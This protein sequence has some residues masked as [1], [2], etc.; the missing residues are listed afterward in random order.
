MEGTKTRSRMSIKLRSCIIII[1]ETRYPSPCP[2]CIKETMS[3]ASFEMSQDMVRIIQVR[4]T[5]NMHKLAYCTHGK[6]A[7]RSS[8]G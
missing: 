6:N 4:S 8:I 1:S 2:Y 5:R 7:I 3:R